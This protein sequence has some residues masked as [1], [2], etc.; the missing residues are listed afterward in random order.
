MTDITALGELL[1]DFTQ[2]GISEAGMMLFERN[3]GGAVANVLSA[4]SKCGCTTA[5]I[6]KVG[7]DMHGLFLKKTLEDAGIDTHGML[8]TH[9]VFTTLAFVELSQQGERTFAF[10]RKPGAD[11]C[12]RS[13][14]LDR[15]LLQSTKILHIGSLS[16]TNEPARSATLEAIRIAKASGALLSYDPNYRAV[17]WPDEQTACKQMRSI[18]GNVDLI[19]LSKE[20]VCLITDCDSPADAALAL[21]KSGISIVTV[22]LGSEGSMACVNGKI[23]SVP[24]YRVPVVD[25]TGAGDCFWGTFLYRL[26]DSGKRPNDISLSEAAEFL[27]WG[28]AAAAL[29]IGR[30]GAIPAMPVINDIKVLIA[31]SM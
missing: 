5:F 9:D 24:G 6:G 13:D 1:I 17:L 16:L 11:T 30:R 10:A 4:A 3:P 31:S 12:L 19:K 14:E 20:E 2:Y 18:L 15:Q 8:V 25:T 28:N 21:H 22:T 7:R 23:V 26:L 27:K 29:C